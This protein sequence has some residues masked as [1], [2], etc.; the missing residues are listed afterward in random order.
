RSVKNSIPDNSPR[1]NSVSFAWGAWRTVFCGI[2]TF[3][4]RSSR[5]ISRA[6]CPQTISIAW[7]VGLRSGAVGPFSLCAMVHLHEGGCTDPGNDHFASP[8]A[9]RAPV[10]QDL[11]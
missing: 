11:R 3:A 6:K 8:Q 5:P 7:V 2:G 4:N 1:K 10:A 9:N